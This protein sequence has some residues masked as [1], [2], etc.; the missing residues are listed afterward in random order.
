MTLASPQIEALFAFCREYNVTYYDVQVELVDHMASAIEDMITADPKLT[1]EQAKYK[2]YKSF[3][4]RGFS[5]VVE[6][7]QALAHKANRRRVW[8]LFLS[9]FTWPKITQSLLLLTALYCLQFYFG[10]A[11]LKWVTV[12]GM[13]F[14]VAL[15]VFLVYRRWRRDRKPA[16]PL[17]MI[18]KAWVTQ[19]T[20]AMMV[21]VYFNLFLGYQRLDGKMHFTPLNYDVFVIT[22]V[23]TLPMILAVYKTKARL[24]QM[25][26]E[27]YPAAFPIPAS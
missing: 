22:F 6:D 20:S 21:N 11:A 23:I 14:M 18:Q 1:F 15:E 25:A 9:Y 7:R 13:A 4:Y 17:L 12:A 26:R 16:T 27:K 19:F 24:Y 2:A 5:R 8:K 10:A 3:G